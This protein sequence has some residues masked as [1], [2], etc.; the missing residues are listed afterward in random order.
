MKTIN[1]DKLGVAL[2]IDENGHKVRITRPRFESMLNDDEVWKWVEET[3]QLQTP[4]F[5]I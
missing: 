1:N 3:L 5:S 2:D 4:D